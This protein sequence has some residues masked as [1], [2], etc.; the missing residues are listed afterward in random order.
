M[1]ESSSNTVHNTHTYTWGRVNLTQSTTHKQVYTR[2]T[3]IS[4][5][6]SY[7]MVHNMQTYIS[8]NKPSNIMYITQIYTLGNHKCHSLYTDLHTKEV[9]IVINRTLFMK[10]N[11]SIYSV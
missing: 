1:G 8:E 4:A 7:N 11:T 5:N 3:Y 2:V 6:S 9:S 10:Q